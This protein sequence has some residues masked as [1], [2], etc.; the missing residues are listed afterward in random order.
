M[1]TQSIGVMDYF[2]FHGFA[3]RQQFWA[4]VLLANIGAIVGRIALGAAGLD[5]SSLIRSLATLAAL[6]GVWLILAT[7]ARRARDAG[8]SPWWAAG[9][10]IPFIGI[11]MLLVLGL[12]RS[13]SAS[14]SHQGF[15]C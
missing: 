6:V 1:T 4:V 5:E 15:S 7:S 3:R 2:S 12:R 9:M 8:M 10:V 11:I 14:P 13:H